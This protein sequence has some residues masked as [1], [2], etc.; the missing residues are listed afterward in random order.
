M[1]PVSSRRAFLAQ[2]GGAWLAA[3]LPLV[4]TL[5]AHAR[6]AAAQGR[7]FGTL[8]EAEA[9]AFEAVAAQILPSGG[10]PGAREAGV[11]HFADGA[12]GSF[13]ADQLPDIRLGLADLDQRARGMGGA[14]FAE[15]DDEHQ[16]TLLH[17]LEPTPLFQGIWMLTIIG[18]FA[19]PAYGGNRDGAG[20]QLLGMVR[21][22]SYQPPFGYYDARK[23]D[24]D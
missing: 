22:P 24:D 5:S 10:L 9:R 1:D 14:P 6:E 13:F 23:G 18:T 4:L 21:A 7:P 16:K 12:L 2:V 20:Q 3:N 8:A 15:L 17:E 19:E 11:V